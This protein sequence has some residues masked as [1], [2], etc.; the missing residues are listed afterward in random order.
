MGQKFEK[1]KLKVPKI[2]AQCRKYPI[3]HPETLQDHSVYITP[4][5]YIA[6]L[7]PFS[8]HCRTI[9]YLNI[10]S[11][12]IPYLNT[13]NRTIPYP[14]TLSRTHVPKT[15]SAVNQK[16]KTLSTNQNRVISQSESRITSPK[17]SI[18]SPESSITSPESS[19]HVEVPS[20]LEL[21][22]YGPYQ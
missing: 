4:S 7:H 6:E 17:S 19:R 18:V 1:K 15:K 10:P 9:P 20:R 8:K 22:R 11:Q 5:E 14:I 2:V 16:E 3:A 21:S 13:L 12:T